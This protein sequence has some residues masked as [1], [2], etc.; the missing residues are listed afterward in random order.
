MKQINFI[1]TFLLLV[2]LSTVAQKAVNVDT[3][4]AKDIKVE[5]LK[6]FEIGS[7]IYPADILNNYINNFKSS[8]TPI[9]LAY[10]SEKR[11][12]S[13]LT[14][15]SRFRLVGN[16]LNSPVIMYDSIHN[17]Y[18]YSGNDLSY[19]TTYSLGAGID[20]E[21]RWYFGYKKRYL[22]GE[23]RLN[24]GWFLSIPLSLSGT[25]INTYKMPP[26]YDFY[27]YR[28]FGYLSIAPT[29]GC[30]Q[31]ITKELFIEGNLQLANRGL[32]IHTLS[33]KLTITFK[34][35][36]FRLFTELSFKIAYTFK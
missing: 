7:S 18:G 15:I 9:T 20:I 5:S 32:D 3:H 26:L 36:T 28:N 14:L 8:N 19:Q 12:A 13:T 23:A 4:K 11:I 35:P 2:T 24:S 31:A 27:K 16:I 25:L 34:Y 10:F 30:R 33:D 17:G 21:P 22:E 6:G 29:I 1:V